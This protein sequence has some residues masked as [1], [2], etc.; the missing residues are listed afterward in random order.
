LQTFAVDRLRKI[1]KRNLRMPS[2][3]AGS[4][5]MNERVLY[6]AQVLYQ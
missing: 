4:A 1:H 6:S 5:S 2:P 3:G